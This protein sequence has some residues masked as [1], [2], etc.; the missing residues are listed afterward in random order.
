M[1]CFATPRPTLTDKRFGY[2]YSSTTY[3][4]PGSIFVCFLN[5][6]STCMV[7]PYSN[8]SLRRRLLWCILE[9]SHIHTSGHYKSAYLVLMIQ[10]LILTGIQVR[11][12]F[13]VSHTYISHRTLQLTRAVFTCCLLNSCIPCIYLYY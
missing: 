12:I 11:T 1:V 5:I 2:L 13:E 6:N 10:Q 7:L 4:V 9:V 3:R 8:L